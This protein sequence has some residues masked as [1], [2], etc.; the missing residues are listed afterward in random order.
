MT[1]DA[2]SGADLNNQSISLEGAPEALSEVPGHIAPHVAGGERVEYSI[3]IPTRGRWREACS[4]SSEKGLSTERLPFILVKT[5][6][7]L[8]R[9]G[10]PPGRVS[11]WTSDSEEQM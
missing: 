4:I 9:Q 1:G 10:I 2:A 7:F 3:V 6:R 11:L 8:K 5:L